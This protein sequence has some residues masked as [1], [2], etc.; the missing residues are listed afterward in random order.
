MNSKNQKNENS[1]I[2]EKAIQSLRNE[3]V[4]PGP[5]P[6]IRQRVLE[7]TGNPQA[8]IATGRERIETMKLIAKIAAVIVVVIGIAAV[9]AFL[10]GTGSNIAWADVTEPILNAT[11]VAF[12]ITLGDE[13]NEPVAR[14]MNIGTDRLRQEMTVGGQE[15]IS[16]IDLETYKCLALEPAKKYATLIDLK[17]LPNRPENYLE[18]TKGMIRKL[19]DDPGVEVE[20]LGEKEIDGRIAIGFHATGG[21]VDLDITIWS[22]LVTALPV[23]VIQNLGENRTI[24]HDF[25]FD[26]QMDESLFSMDPPEG[27]TLQQTEID[28]TGA[29]EEDFIEAMRILAELLPD[30]RFPD[31]FTQQWLV[32]QAAAIDG[33]IK[34]K[35]LSQKEE[36]EIGMKI[37]QGL[38]FTLFFKAKNDWQ[39]LGGGVSYGDADSPICRYRPDGSEMYRVIYGDLTVEEVAPEELNVP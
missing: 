1:D 26:L 38:M 7:L 35:G 20:E 9:F 4:P 21:N 24:L 37:A 25:E 6:D 33:Q 32:S 10:S 11:S 23:R 30:G 27:Y 34:Q 3:P 19:Q 15:V 12:S 13:S 5:P 29:T 28:I 17:G 2:I 18:T 22:D 16:I 39:Y 31:Q 36:T 8:P 14:L